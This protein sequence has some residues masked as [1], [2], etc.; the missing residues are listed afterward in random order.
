MS[1]EWRKT[2]HDSSATSYII[3]SRK[4]ISTHQTEINGL[5]EQASLKPRCH[6]ENAVAA[7]FSGLLNSYRG[8]CAASLCL[9]LKVQP[10]ELMRNWSKSRCARKTRRPSTCNNFRHPP[11][12]ACQ[13]RDFTA[14]KLDSDF[15]LSAFHRIRWII[16]FCYVVSG[17][18]LLPKEF[19]QF[20]EMKLLRSGAEICSVCKC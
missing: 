11:H 1:V 16:L 15:C 9:N 4:H 3:I 5:I 2:F 19:K 18:F 14:L 12:H 17:T 6:Y 7:I 20:K 8:Y 13:L 10:P